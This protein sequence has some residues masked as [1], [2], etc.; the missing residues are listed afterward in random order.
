M[1]VPV[2]DASAISSVTSGSSATFA[3]TCTGS[4]LTLVVG[5]MIGD[6]D[7]T[8]GKTITGVTYNSVAMTSIGVTRGFSN[9]GT[10]IVYMF[11]LGNP[12]TGANN[13]V[14][15][16]NTSLD[17]GDRVTSISSSYTGTDTASP[18]GGVATGPAAG[19]T[20]SAAVTTTRS[21]S[22]IIGILGW[23]NSNLDSWNGTELQINGSGPRAQAQYKSAVSVGSNPLT[24][25][26][27][28]ATTGGAVA[29]ELKS[30]ITGPANV[31]TWNGLP[32][33][34][35]KTINGL[36]VESIKTINGLN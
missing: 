16:F 23:M 2:L 7:N 17:A 36:A 3:H 15:T 10:G 13:V 20:I 4:D 8:I 24:W 21:D 5:V 26:W 28:G 6:S 1:A 35:I 31:K 12:A 34:S 18:L 27:G 9:T 32:L 11:Y 22:L 30:P 14:V 25:T 19:E 33:A 29:M